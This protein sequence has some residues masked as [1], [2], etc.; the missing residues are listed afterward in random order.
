MSNIIGI[1]LGTTFSVISKLDDNGQ[2]FVVKVDGERIMPSC[3]S[4]TSKSNILVGR[5][6]KNEVPSEPDSIV[7]RFKG[8]MGS[9]VVYSRKGVDLTPISASAAVHSRQLF[10]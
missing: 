6:A 5:E 3:L 2:P 8:E 4:V 10:T 7:H 9:D 1:D